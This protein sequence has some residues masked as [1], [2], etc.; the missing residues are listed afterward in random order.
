[1]SYLSSCITM[2]DIMSVIQE[3]FSSIIFLD[4]FADLE[5][6]RIERHKLYPLDEIFLTTL[7]ANICDAQSW[8]DIEDFGKA[9]IEFLK[10][11]LPYKNGIPS[12]DT[13]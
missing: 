5:D 10:K 3:D 11:Y 7:C 1:M 13:F 4:F 6:P 12:H 2:E 8:E 9:K